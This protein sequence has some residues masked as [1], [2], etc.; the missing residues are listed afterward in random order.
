MTIKPFGRAGTQPRRVLAR[1]VKVCGAVVRQS[2][3][4]LT[5][6]F[7]V[8]PTNESHSMNLS[9]RRKFATSFATSVASSIC[10]AAPV[11]PNDPATSWPEAKFSERQAYAQRAAVACQSTNCGSVEIRACMDEA[12]RAPAP[13]SAKNT[14][15]GEAAVICIAMLKSQR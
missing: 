5:P 11:S 4:V 1:A 14:T 10:I 3:Q 13:P 12:F 2:R 8:T 9:L 6:A 7:N 15:I